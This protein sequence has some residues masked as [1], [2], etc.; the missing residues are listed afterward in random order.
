VVYRYLG[1]KLLQRVWFNLDLL[2]AVSLIAVGGIALA[3]AGH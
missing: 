1:L 2:W 3:A